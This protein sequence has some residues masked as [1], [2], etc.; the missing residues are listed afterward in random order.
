MSDSPSPEQQLQ[1]I[2]KN[3]SVGG[4]L[5]TGDISQ[6][7]N[8]VVV[9]Q[10]NTFIPKSTPYNIPSS[11][12]IKFVGRA[13]ALE[14][15]HQALQQNSQVAITAIEGMGGVGKTELATQYSL[16]HLLL[17]T[18]P[19]GI[20]WLRARDEN[21]G[22]QILRFVEAKLGIKPP[23]DWDIRDRVDFCWS[24]WQEKKEGNVLIVLDDVNDYPKIQSYLPPQLSQFKVLITTRLQL[25]LPQSF[26]LDILSEFASLE[27]LRQWIGKEKVNEE[28]AE[29][30]ELCLR[31]GNLPLALNLVGRYVQ[32]RKISL[33]EMLLRLE[34]E[35]KGLQ[36]P[37]LDVDKKDCTRTLNNQLGVAAAF[38]LSWEELSED[39]QKL[40]CFLSLFALA[41]IPWGLVNVTSIDLDEEKLED[42]KIQLSDLHL[43]QNTNPCLLHQLIRD[44]LQQKLIQLQLEEKKKVFANNIVQYV[45]DNFLNHDDYSKIKNYSI[46]IPHVEEIAKHMNKYLEDDDLTNCFKIIVKFYFSMGNLDL[47][48]SWSKC[49]LKISQIRFN[50]NSIVFAE[51]LNNLSLI[52][53]TKNKINEAESFCI[54]ALDIR[55]K[56]I[57]I[58]DEELAEI[59]NNLALIYHIKKVYT[60]AENYYK[61]AL[62]IYISVFNDHHP[63][64]ATVQNN[65]AGL[66][67][68]LKKYE[69]AEYLF[70]KS[71]SIRKEYFG[72]E[73]S[74]VAASLK[75]LGGLYFSQ[76]YLDKAEILYKKSLD[77]RQKLLGEAHPTVA[78]SLKNLA[79]L[80]K[81]QNKYQLAIPLLKKT[82]KIRQQTLGLKHP[83]INR[84]KLE[85]NA[86]TL[87]LNSENI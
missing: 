50:K 45:S 61:K 48:E 78:T 66:Y 46:N 43:V 15:L 60:E 68:S 41:P 84:L 8:F 70:L 57:D 33:A 32:K 52:L 12:T 11:N 82:L 56:L 51:C 44:F 16:L 65:L 87:S 67:S 76:G 20:C 25:D 17:D 47:A 72:E 69:Q 83:L 75:N 30:E 7:L 40:G 37:A 59:M 80:Y 26:S 14:Q 64:V 13:D 18:Y 31:L 85:L 53:Y 39:A 62:E 6:I 1:N 63:V 34:L 86:M 10:P 24:R 29:A 38:E 71:L 23:E 3:I 19:G 55:Q 81:A 21:I 58:Q 79:D 73:H 42:A 54:Q 49:W 28:L 9:Q 74:T 5:T 22:I 4:N 35:H 27:L 77:I 36:H 2:L